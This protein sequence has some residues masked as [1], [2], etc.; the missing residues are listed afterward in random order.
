MNTSLSSSSSRPAAWE[1]FKAASGSPHRKNP[2]LRQPFPT[3]LDE[4]ITGLVEAF[5]QLDI[6]NRGGWAKD[7]P[8]DVGDSQLL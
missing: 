2:Y 6:G 8:M 3:E 1:R 5:R 4:A 7:L